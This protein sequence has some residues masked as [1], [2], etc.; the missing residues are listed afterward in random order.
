MNKPH[1]HA[2]LIKAWADGERIERKFYTG[3]W[4][5]VSDPR[6]FEDTEYRIHDEYR[7]LKEAYAEGKSMQYL[8]GKGIWQPLT[9]DQWIYTS[10]RYRIKPTTKTVKMWQWIVKV[11]GG[12]IYLDSAFSS[13]PI[14]NVEFEWIRKAEWTEIEVEVDE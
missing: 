1:K 2:E 5:I 3:Q 9:D 13:T 12:G 11:K 6:W 8:S 4:D 14:D 7:E 10:D